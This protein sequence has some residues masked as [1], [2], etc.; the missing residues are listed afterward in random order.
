MGQPMSQIQATLVNDH[1]LMKQVDKFAKKTKR[2][3]ANALRYLI[4]IG[5]GKIRKWQEDQ[6]INAIEPT[7]PDDPADK[8][9]DLM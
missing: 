9:D 1:D 7:Q 5:L 6:E 8:L 3:R 4:G 2:T